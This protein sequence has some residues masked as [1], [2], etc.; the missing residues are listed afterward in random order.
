VPSLQAAGKG[1]NALKSTAA[2]LER[3]TRA[4][5]LMLSSTVK[6]DFAI[7]RDWRSLFRIIVLSKPVRIDAHRTGNTLVA[8]QTIPAAVQIKNHDLFARVQLLFKLFWRDPR[9]SKFAHKAMPSN[10]LAADVY[11]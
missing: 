7:A 4:R 5:E 8:S 6:D 1:S 11:S 2:Q 3:C 10:K 9:H